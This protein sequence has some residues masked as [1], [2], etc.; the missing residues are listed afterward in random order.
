MGLSLTW[1]PKKSAWIVSA[2]T[3]FGALLAKRNQSRPSLILFRRTLG[4]R[5][6][7]QLELL[8]KNFESIEQALVRGSVVVFENSRIRIREL[9]IV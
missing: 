9:A 1:L 5:P 7:V 4:R 3:D 6:T 2:D 8:L